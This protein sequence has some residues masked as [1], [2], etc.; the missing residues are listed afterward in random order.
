[1]KI[2]LICRDCD[3]TEII[4]P[5]DEGIF[6]EAKRFNIYAPNDMEA[7]IVCKDCGKTNKLLI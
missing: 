2:I 3:N 4:T 5:N 1:M 7:N 6:K